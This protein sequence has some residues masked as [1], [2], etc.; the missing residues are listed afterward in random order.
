MGEEKEKL[1]RLQ[2]KRGGHRTVVTKNINEARTILEH[3]DLEDIMRSRLNVVEQILDEKLILRAGFGFWEFHHLVPLPAAN[4]NAWTSGR[5][6]LSYLIVPS[7]ILTFAAALS[8]ASLASSTA[9]LL[10]GSH[11]DV[12]VSTMFSHQ[13][14]AAL[15]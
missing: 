9:T 1:D 2:A 11:C 8:V 6:V 15:V 5:P 7:F 3:T 13:R 12:A 4:I 14:R 10:F